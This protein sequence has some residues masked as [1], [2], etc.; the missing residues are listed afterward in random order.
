MPQA[1]DADPDVLVPAGKKGMALQGNHE[2][3]LKA[4]LGLQNEMEAAV[5][6]PG[7]GQAIQQALTQSWDKG[8][9]LA[10][11]LQEILTTL[12]DTAHKIGATD[13]DNY[14]QVL[15]AAGAGDS[16]SGAAL[17]ADGVNSVA[18]D[19]TNVNPNT[20][21]GKIDVQW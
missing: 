1:M 6:S 19:V 7:G 2:G 13:L 9:K 4:L 18:G 10:N 5:K 3:Y 20:H 15:R 11:S 16:H 17:A 12:L 14:Q 8:N 21:I